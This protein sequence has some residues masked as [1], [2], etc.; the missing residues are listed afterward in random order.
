MLTPKQQALTE[1]YLT[2]LPDELATTYR[3][4]MDY[5][6]E[7]GYMP[8]K[9]KSAITYK[10]ADHNKQLAKFGFANTKAR[11]PFFALRFSACRDYSARIAD[12][13]AAQIAKYPGKYACCTRG[14]C[15]FCAGEPSTRVYTHVTNDGEIK[16]YCGAQALKIP[17]VTQGD[18]DE[19]KRM[20]WQ[21]HAY[22]MRHQA[23]IEL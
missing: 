20:I 9:E 3:A 8:Y 10:C 21:E 1:A 6:S 16:T 2:Q 5:L 14:E 12:I 23:G 18:I 19:L 15:N 17:D 22:L 11:T 7:V 13:V 4:L